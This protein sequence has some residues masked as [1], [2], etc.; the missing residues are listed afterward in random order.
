MSYQGHHH[1]LSNTVFTN[2]SQNNSGFQ[3]IVHKDYDDEAEIFVCKYLDFTQDREKI[4]NFINSTGPSGGGGAECY[5][6]ALHKVRTE[7]SW[8]EGTTTKIRSLF[9]STLG[10]S[11]L[12]TICTLNRPNLKPM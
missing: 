3:V 11:K 7:L 9:T 8:R 10:H 5:E 12:M 2:S 6:L 1:P 4:C